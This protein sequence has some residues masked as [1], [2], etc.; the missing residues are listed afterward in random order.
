MTLASRLWLV[1]LATV[2]VT[3]LAV[4]LT[5]DAAL[6]QTLAALDAEQRVRVLEGSAL[7]LSNEV[8]VLRAE[9]Y[10]IG[11]AN[12]TRAVLTA[13][14][15][16][17]PLPGTEGN[18][19]PGMRALL[20][21]H[22]NFL[23]VR[24]LD[25]EGREVVRI[26]RL[27]PG[28][29]V[30][31][32]TG[33]ALE[34][35]GA[36]LD[37]AGALALASGVVALSPVV[38]APAGSSAGGVRRAV[39][40]ASTPVDD[41]QGR[42]MGAVAVTLDLQAVLEGMRA[43][44]PDGQLYLVDGEGRF[45]LHPD[46]ARE[47]GHG[48]AGPPFGLLDQFPGA[49]A[50]LAAS[51][52]RSG[53]L[54]VAGAGER[55]YSVAPIVGAAA[56][57]L[58]LILTERENAFLESEVRRS[59]F[60]AALGAALLA[61]L[62]AI[63]FARTVTRPLAAM[64]EAARG[65]LDSHPPPMPA[66]AQGEVG[67][68][69]RALERMQATMRERDVFREQEQRRFR[70]VVEAAPNA[71]LM[72]DGQRRVT[73][74]NRNAELLFGRGREELVGMDIESLMPERYRAAHPAHVA[75]FLAAPRARA[76]GAGS[77][78]HVLR[79]DGAE[80]AVE[81]GLNPVASPGAGL[82]MLVSVSDITERRAAEGTRA[83]LAAIV[84]GSED[85]ILSKSPGS[86]VTSWNRGAQKLLGYSAEE[87]IGRSVL[88]L[89]PER[90]A[91]EEA[92]LMARLSAGEHVAHYETLRL[93][94][95]GREIDVS[96]TLS[97][98]LTQGVLTGVSSIMRDIRENKRRDAELRR[99]NA[100]LEQFAYVASH[101]LQEPLRMVANYTELLAERYRGRLDERADKYIHYAS[102]GARRMQ[103]LVSDLLAYS[104]VGSQGRPLLPT[105]SDR[106]L[107]RV[108][109]MLRRLVQESEARVEFDGLPE[110]MADEGQLHQLFQNLIGNAIK[111]R[112]EAPPR[113]VVK[114][115]PAG[116][117]WQFS[118]SDNGIGLEMR[119]AERIF[120]M[121]QRLHELGRYEGSG[122][123]LAIS[124]RIVERHGGRIWVESTPGVGTT[125]HFTLARVS[126]GSV[127]P[128]PAVDGH[129]GDGILA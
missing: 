49:Q 118:V 12:P 10:S 13:H 29:P 85:A 70:D 48:A 127:A 43:S 61:S 102:D 65:F 67:V 58:A 110:V 99:S 122:I 64:T 56:T 82:Q 51:A 90:L 27:A 69:A 120:Q 50:L 66:R 76:M 40:R 94:R 92:R 104:R 6:R 28:A 7:R 75:Q 88:M 93:H 52:P 87:V 71:M 121:F 108:L 53:R 24:M 54:Q 74:V 100:E 125:F 114:A 117:Q 63:P 72:V 109:E 112:G 79:A 105:S 78:L 19:L 119:Y 123:G 37:V 62:L 1:L 103:R 83:R 116:P 59:T 81:I 89:I 4:E 22:P 26:E 73:L 33:R 8:R 106:V 86:I 113:I 107:R 34:D 30:R 101:D 16:Q 46:R 45:I 41:A 20:G 95:D 25:A 23:D 18:R 3:A 35:H 98:I 124:K 115:V 36:N 55:A 80:V 96:V 47:S 68:L 126:A 111:F 57:P 9:A 91:E 21:W 32:A 60:L 5:V 44:M 39:L 31:V 38:F 77:D 84:E 42:R 11:Q 97:P 14:A 129:G 128:L 15:E 17:Q 2:A